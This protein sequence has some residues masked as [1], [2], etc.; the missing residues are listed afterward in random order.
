MKYLLLILSLGIGFSTHAETYKCEDGNGKISYSSN[1]CKEGSR[2]QT[3]SAIY[4]EA[5]DIPSSGNLKKFVYANTPPFK[6]TTN[7]KTVIAMQGIEAWK[8]VQK[9]SGLKDVEIYKYDKSDAKSTVTLS[10]RSFK[11]EASASRFWTNT[12]FDKNE[13]DIKSTTAVT[14]RSISSFGTKT[15]AFYMK[16]NSYF[17]ELNIVS[18]DSD[19][20][21]EL[22]AT[23]KEYSDF[24]KNI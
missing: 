9:Q 20:Q 6:L 8:N 13:Y 23:F 19:P 21:S 4:K 24:V 2:E 7:K 12:K 10:I 18:F 22:E 17:I 11:N 3:L 1:K 5:T 16:H 14:L 15:S